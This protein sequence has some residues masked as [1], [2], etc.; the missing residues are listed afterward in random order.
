MAGYQRVYADVWDQPWDQDV[1]YLAFYL[2]TCQHRVTEGLFR[3]PQPYVWADLQWTPQRFEEAF[4]D[5]LTDGFAEYDAKA[6]VILLPGALELQ[7]PANPNNVKSAVKAVAR[8][9]KTPLFLRFYRL[10]EQFAEPLAKGL[11][12]RFP[13]RLAEPI[14][15]SPS[16]APSQPISSEIG[17]HDV[18][19]QTLREDESVGQPNLSIIEGRTA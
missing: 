18:A 13:E 4:G 17:L 11:A 3:L 15:N 8:L 12:E 9:P 2:M 19:Q 16:P 7:Q 1:R 14:G 10:A 6:Q 5:L